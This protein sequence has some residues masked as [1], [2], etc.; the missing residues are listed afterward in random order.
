MAA[1]CRDLRLMILVLCSVWEDAGPGVIGIL[2]EKMC[3]F[4][5]PQHP[6]LVQFPSWIPLSVC[7][8]AALRGVGTQP[9]GARHWTGWSVFLIHTAWKVIQESDSRSVVPGPAFAGNFQNGSTCAH[10]DLTKW[11]LWGWVRHLYYFFLLCPDFII[12]QQK[13]QHRV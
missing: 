3:I 5:G 7:F 8:Q 2:P 12:L 4:T 9:C 10:P 1:S 6:C 11:R 13:S